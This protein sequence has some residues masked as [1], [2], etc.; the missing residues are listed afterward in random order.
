[1]QKWRSS[2][3][4]SIPAFWIPKDL[5]NDT[6]VELSKVEAGCGL[7]MERFSLRL[8]LSVKPLKQ[9]TLRAFGSTRK[10]DGGDTVE[11]ACPSWQNYCSGEPSLFACQSMRKTSQ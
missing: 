6:R 11:V 9:P 10:S 5:P 3:A 1:M 2:R 4:L 7:R 8:T